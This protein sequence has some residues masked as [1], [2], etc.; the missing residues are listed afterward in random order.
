M[1]KLFHAAA[2]AA[3]RVGQDG[4]D[5]YLGMRIVISVNRMKVRSR[6]REG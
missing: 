2:A 6:G 5:D 4:F 1:K 3:A